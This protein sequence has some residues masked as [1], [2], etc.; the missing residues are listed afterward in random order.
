M[1]DVSIIYFPFYQ[2]QIHQSKNIQLKHITLL[3]II[4]YQ[5]RQYWFVLTIWLYI[6]WPFAQKQDSSNLRTWTANHSLVL[7]Y[8]LHCAE[9]KRDF[10]NP[11]HGSVVNCSAKTSIEQFLL[12]KHFYRYRCWQAK[13]EV[14]F[15]S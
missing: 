7:L 1:Y 6:G 13:K 11:G 9:T 2:Q 12:P 8:Q 14:K 5:L 15:K 4:L 3:V 10:E